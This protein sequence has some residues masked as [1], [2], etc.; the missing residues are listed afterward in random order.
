MPR[1]AAFSFDALLQRI[2]PAASR[3]QQAGGGNAGAVHR[4]RPAGRRATDASLT[5]MPL[6]ERRARAGSLRAKYCR[7]TA[8]IPAVAGDDEA[9][10][11]RKTLARSASARRSTAS[12][13]SGATC[14][15]APATATACRRSRTIAPPT[16]SSA[17]SATTKASRVVGSLL[18]G[19]YDDDGLL[20]HVGFTSTIT[21]RRQAGADR[22]AGEADRAAGLH[23]QRAR[24]SEPLVDRAL[25][26]MAAAASRSSWSRSATTISPATASVTARDCCAGGRTSR[27]E[28]C[29]MEQVSQKT[30]SLTKL[31]K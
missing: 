10:A 28:Q 11:T 15:T 26:R 16:A 9:R 22:K 29:T 7:R 3:V 17:A 24:R 20:H 6:R 8:A 1:T 30:A 18:L 12:S 25:R 13:P 2:H 19:L 4:V 14:R 21:A 5:G 31:L 23:R 27:R